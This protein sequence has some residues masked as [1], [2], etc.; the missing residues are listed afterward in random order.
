MIERIKAAIRRWLGVSASQAAIVAA[1]DKQ[2]EGMR[3]SSAT[4]WESKRHG[5]PINAAAT[6][7]RPSPA[8]GVLPAGYA[9]DSLPAMPDMGAAAYASMVS[10]GLGFLGYQY[11]AELSQ[12]AEYRKIA[13]IW[14]DHCVRK[15]IKF[16][17]D[18]EKTKKIEAELK[19]LKVR[20][21]L[22]EAIE[23]ESFFGRIQIFMDLA[24]DGEKSDALDDEELASRLIITPEKIS[25]KRPLQRLKIVQPLWSYPGWY[26][27]ANPLSPTFYKPQEWFV[28]GRIV[29]AS[30]LLTIVS[31][32]MPD[33][34]KP[35]YAFG[36][37]SMAQMAKPYVDNW[38]RNRQSGSDLLNAFTRW[39]LK[40]DMEQM[41]SGGGGVDLWSRAEFF[42]NVSDNRGLMI[43]DKNKEELENISTPL[44]GV[45]ALVAQ[46]Q[47]HMSAVSGIP[48]VQLLGITPSGLNASSEGEIRVFYDAILSYLERNIREPLDQIVKIVQLSLFGEIDE[49]IEYEFVSLWE[50]SDRDKADIRKVNADAAAVY[51]AA[52]VV[53]DE[54]ERERLNNEE[55][56]FYAGMLEGA[57]PEMPQEDEDFFGQAGK[58]RKAEQDQEGDEE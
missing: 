55:E 12:R 15:W 13:Q 11:L 29:N 36:G 5:A 40:T 57:P 46:S 8:N 30:R 48:L 26:E 23:M 24:T 10:E 4:L 22:R 49:E 58:S 38:L 1:D 34:L 6:F 37:I 41:L 27:S 19:R 31:H 54:E 32:E 14:A 52:G 16:A 53:S 39:V 7:K 43:I 33:M 3:I 51:I 2:P 56:G 9:M 47:E 44:S 18:E 20:D 25:P 35:A 17:G 28:M 21:I 50:M 42:T 45:D